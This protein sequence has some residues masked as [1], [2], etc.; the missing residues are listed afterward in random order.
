MDK[1]YTTS[2]VSN[3]T[4]KTKFSHIIWHVFSRLKKKFKTEN[5]EHIKLHF[6]TVRKALYSKIVI[7]MNNFVGHNTELS[8]VM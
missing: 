2:Q 5:K 3:I 7:I 1:L 6:F 4:K 8:L